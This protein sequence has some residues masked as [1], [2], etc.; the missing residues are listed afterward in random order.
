MAIQTVTVYKENGNYFPDGCEKSITCGMIKSLGVGISLELPAG[1]PLACD[2]DAPEPVLTEL[3]E[4]SNGTQ[5]WI[6]YDGVSSIIQKCADA[7]EGGQIEP[8]TFIVN[9]PDNPPDPPVEGEQTWQN[10]LFE[11]RYIGISYNGRNLPTLDPGNGNVWYEKPLADVEAVFHNMPDGFVDE[12][13]LIVT[14][15]TP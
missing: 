8:L 11:N 3:I 5:W 2:E 1:A 12:D 10:P 14:F 13:E 9:G 6:E 4:F 15:I 7:A